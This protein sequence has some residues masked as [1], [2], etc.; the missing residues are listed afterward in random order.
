[1]A[2]IDYVKSLPDAYKKHS[3]SNNYKLLL[4]EEQLVGGLK[5]DIEAVHNTLDIYSATGKTLDLYGAML[6][7]PRGSATDEQYRYL[8]LQKVAQNMVTGDY[9]SIVNAISVAFDVPVTE[10]KFVETENPVEV[11]CVNLPYGVILNAG[12]TEDQVRKIISNLLP[13]GV[14]LEINAFAGTFEFSAVADEY[15][16]N[17]G[18]GNV[19]QTI[20]GYFGMLAG[21]GV[22]K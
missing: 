20:G 17:A 14:K 3:E 18:F 2:I 16:E 10:F 7:A 11:E 19:D 12:I 15:D 6:G 13:I 4:M 5:E 21:Q 9:N 8:I 1:M 22:I